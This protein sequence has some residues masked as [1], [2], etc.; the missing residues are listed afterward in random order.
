MGAMSNVQI[1]Y[2]HYESAHFLARLGID[3][4]DD[5]TPLGV[6]L[7]QLLKSLNMESTVT[8]VH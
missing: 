6:V 4:H 3:S 2:H 7:E 1:R 8:H 5:E